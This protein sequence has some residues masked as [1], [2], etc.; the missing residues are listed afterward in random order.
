[1]T[2]ETHELHEDDGDIV[3]VVAQR[4]HR[5]LETGDVAMVVGAP[6]VDQTLVAALKF[7]AMVS[8]VRSEIGWRAVGAYQDLVLFLAPV[9]GAQPLSAVFFVDNALFA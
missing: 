6:D 1:M 3:A 8:D 4:R 9:G 5:A 2:I 7:I